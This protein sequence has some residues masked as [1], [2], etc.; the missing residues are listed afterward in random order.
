MLQEA[1]AV[2]L[3]MVSTMVG[4]CDEVVLEGE[5][6][7]LVPKQEPKALADAMLR[8]M[9]LSKE[10][11]AALGAASKKLVEEEFAMEQVMKKWYLLYRGEK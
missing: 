3:P 7:Y 1:A 10:E 4:G 6:G 11:Q 2:G 9:E 8:I 5:N